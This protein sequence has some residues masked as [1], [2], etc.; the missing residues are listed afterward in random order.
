MHYLVT[1]G[2]GF[3]GSNIAKLLV[4]K[5]KNVTVIDNLYRG[6]LSNLESIIDKI[7]F[8]KLDIRNYNDIKAVSKNIDGIFHQAALTSVPESYIRSKDY[9]DVNVH[10]TENIFK[11]AHELKKKVVYASSS[12]VYGNTEKIPIKENFPRNPANPYGQT[13]LDDELLAESYYKKDNMIIGL[14]YFNVYGIGQNIDYAG[15]IKKFL[16]NIDKGQPL[17][18]FGDGNQTRDFV[19]VLDVSQANLTAM[20]SNIK[21]GFFNIGTGISTSIISLANIIRDISQKPIELIF[22]DL[23]HGDVKTSLADISYSRDCLNWVSLISLKDGLKI[24]M[25]N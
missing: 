14:R 19:N 25:N 23:P 3:I 2:A 6:K 1:G 4:E 11:I 15:V 20:E 8:H 21:N 12:S 18:I 24:L 7:N 17:R 5:G 22:E 9:Q 16:E 10:G 13:K